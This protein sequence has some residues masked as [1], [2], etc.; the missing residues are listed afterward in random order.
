MQQFRPRT[1]HLV[2]NDLDAT[3][4]GAA[5]RRMEEV[6]RIAPGITDCDQEPINFLPTYVVPNLNDASGQFGLLERR[7]LHQLHQH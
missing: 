4:A 1:K 5:A 2:A 6:D 7:S 3:R